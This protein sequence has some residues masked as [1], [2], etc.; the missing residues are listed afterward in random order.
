MI[1]KCP[2]QPLP[3]ATDARAGRRGRIVLIAIMLVGGVT[4]FG[5]GGAQQVRAEPPDPCEHGR[6]EF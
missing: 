2:T 3:A 1:M 4:P 5:L 6:C